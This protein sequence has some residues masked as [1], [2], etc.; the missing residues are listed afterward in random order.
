M[1]RENLDNL[2]SELLPGIEID[3]FSIRWVLDSPKATEESIRE[4]YRFLKEKSLSDDKIATLAHLLGRNPET[5][6]RNYKRL[7]ALGLSDEKIANK[8]ICLEEILKPLR[9]TIII[10]LDY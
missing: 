3:Q 6:E 7:S 8:H 1:D 4:V 9:E 10:M 5:I 2:L